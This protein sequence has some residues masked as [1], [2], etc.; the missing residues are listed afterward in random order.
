MSEV[1]S[2][3]MNQPLDPSKKPA[4]AKYK[5]ILD[6]MLRDKSKAKV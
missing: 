3:K 1:A 6:K 4:K 2:L 5:E